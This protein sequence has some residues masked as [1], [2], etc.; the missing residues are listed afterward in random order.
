MSQAA[1]TLEEVETL[2]GSLASL[3]AKSAEMRAKFEDK[4]KEDRR[5]YLEHLTKLKEGGVETG[6]PVPESPVKV[7]E[8]QGDERGD[9]S[10]A[11]MGGL[12]E[13]ADADMDIDPTAAI[14]AVKNAAGSLLK[15]LW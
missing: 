1:Q 13:S 8:V 12:D 6:L 3:K 9:E 14:S 7:S 2:K 11:G 5:K 15:G 10:A 4:I